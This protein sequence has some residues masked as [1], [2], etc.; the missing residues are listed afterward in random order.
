[1]RI[2]ARR[3]EDGQHIKIEKVKQITRLR[4]DLQRASKRAGWLLEEEDSI[5]LLFD[6]IAQI[7]SC[8]DDS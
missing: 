3:L 1:M 7:I 4:T 6:D 5:S 2:T 8:S